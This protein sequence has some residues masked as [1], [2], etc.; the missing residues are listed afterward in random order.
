MSRFILIVFEALSIAFEVCYLY[1]S[2][3]SIIL[4]F[5]PLFSTYFS[6][7]YSTSIPYCFEFI[8]FF[9]QFPSFDWKNGLNFDR[10]FIIN[11]SVEVASV[12][13]A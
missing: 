7:D 8:I 1:Q 4:E 13:Q 3:P 9:L 10:G 2:L 11:W 5:T 12:E 6:H